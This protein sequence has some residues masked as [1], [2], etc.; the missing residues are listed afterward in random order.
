MGYTTYFNG[1]FTVTPPLAPEQV[2]YLKAFA[3]TRRM[4][5]DPAIVIN[6][7]DPLRI[8]AGIPEVGI[9]GEYYVGSTDDPGGE[10][11]WFSGH[12]QVKDDSILNYNHEPATQPGL[13][14]QWVPSDDGTTI[15]WDQGEKF[16]SYVE[17]ITYIIE[18]FLTRWGRTLNGT[19]SW[20]G[21]DDYDMGLIRITDNKV[22][23]GEAE[24]T[25]KFS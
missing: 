25:Y 22:S 21:E 2:A 17:W 14:C 12:G 9:D 15:A 7:Y 6:L 10:G 11:A 8:A 18:H 1:E 23:I 24:I 16:Y 20:S 4:K 19:V 13:W 3:D 5:R